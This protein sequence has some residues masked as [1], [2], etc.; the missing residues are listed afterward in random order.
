MIQL[1]PSEPVEHVQV[2][3]LNLFLRYY[4]RY[5]LFDCSVDGLSSSIPV[6]LLSP[7]VSFSFIGQFLP[8][9]NS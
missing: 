4:N 3:L 6:L 7:S 9:V 5:S 2:G 8:Q 1:C